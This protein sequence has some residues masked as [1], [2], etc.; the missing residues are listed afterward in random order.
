M[1][2]TF[3]RSVDFLL[4]DDGRTL[5]G[6]IVPYNEPTN[7]VEANDETG[8]LDRYRE[9]FLPNSMA[10]MVQGF[11]ARGGNVSKRSNVF[12]PLLIAHT[13]NFD[14]MIGHAIELEER[15]D[16]AYATFRLYDDERIT[17]IRSVLTESHTGLSVSFRDIKMP[18][19]IDG[20]VSRVQVAI[21]HVAATPTPAYAGAGIASMRETGEYLSGTPLLDEVTEWLASMRNTDAE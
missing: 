14:N 18:R 5:E 16:G 8:T 7:I 13:D 17:K 19:M 6:R 2:E 1:T 3:Y 20:V 4:R 10:A 9:Q 21:N 12:V 15:D 11:N